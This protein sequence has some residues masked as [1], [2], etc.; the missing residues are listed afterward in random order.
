[1]FMT[2]NYP[3]K[4]QDVEYIYTYKKV[5]FCDCVCVCGEYVRIPLQGIFTFVN[6]KPKEKNIST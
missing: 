6:S 2:P 1:M 5:L 4:I 3:I